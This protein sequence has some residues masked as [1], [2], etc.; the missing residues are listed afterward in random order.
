MRKDTMKRLVFRNRI[1]LVLIPNIFAL[2]GC[3][4]ISLLSSL[5][6]S[7][8]EQN[9]QDDILL[10]VPIYPN[11]TLVSSD[12]A[13]AW[14]DVGHINRTY[15]TTDTFEDVM[16]FYTS[17]SPTCTEITFR[18]RVDDSWDCM[19]VPEGDDRGYYEIELSKSTSITVYSVYIE[20]D[21]GYLDD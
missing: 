21:C 1:I 11:S 17:V 3:I 6:L 8:S 18:E 16:A 2:T 10:K 20:W 14:P 12:D 4:F 9:C 15:K 5:V 13:M 19:G 7:P